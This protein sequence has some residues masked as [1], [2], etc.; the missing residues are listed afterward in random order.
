MYEGFQEG[1]AR[2]RS[3]CNSLNNTVLE[4]TSDESR[5]GLLWSPSNTGSSNTNTEPSADWIKDQFS[6]STLAE[7]NNKISNNTKNLKN[8]NIISSPDTKEAIQENLLEQGKYLLEQKSK[9]LN[10]FVKEA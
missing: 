6:P 8:I 5:K 10:S 9:H 4:S 7:L 2:I 3:N 1:L